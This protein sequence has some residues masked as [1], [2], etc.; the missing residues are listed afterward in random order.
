MARKDANAGAKETV[1]MRRRM[2]LEYRKAGMSY[3]A[4]ADKLGVAP[5]QAF[6]DVQAVL[7]EIRAATKETAEDLIQLEEERLDI[8]M[9]AIATRVAK[10]ELGAIDRWIAL[11]ESRRKLRGLDAP[12]K[13]APT[14]PAGDEPYD[15]PSLDERIARVNELLDRARERRDR[16]G[17]GRN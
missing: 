3:R 16:G 11:C 17:T 9:L 15:P 12:K 7:K 10:G 8:A 13:I 5:S 4:V 6:K 14:N 2:A 1:A